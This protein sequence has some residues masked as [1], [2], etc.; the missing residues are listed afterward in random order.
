MKFSDEQL[1][2][3]TLHFVVGLSAIAVRQNYLE[4]YAIWVRQRSKFTLTDF[5]HA[6]G[7]SIF[8]GHFTS[9]LWLLSQDRNFYSKVLW[10]DDKWWVLDAK[11]N[12]QNDRIWARSMVENQE[13]GAKHFLSLSKLLFVHGFSKFHISSITL[14]KMKLIRH[15]SRK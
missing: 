5:Q 10:S 11:S 3:I 8:N 6:C 14:R 2:F 1:N 15:F 9:C 4:T 13:K 7:V 12:N